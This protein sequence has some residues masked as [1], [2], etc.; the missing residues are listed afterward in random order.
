MKIAEAI[1]RS[2]SH[3]AY[4]RYR[5]S[6]GNPVSLISSIQQAVRRFFF[7]VKQP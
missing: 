7:E 4:W 3:L 1:R 6:I 5:R 2:K